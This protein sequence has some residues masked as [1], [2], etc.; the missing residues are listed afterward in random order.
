VRLHTEGRPWLQASA[1]PSATKHGDSGSTI[2][3]KGESMAGKKAP[4]DGIYTWNGRQYR[5]RAGEDMPPGAEFRALDSKDMTDS[6]RAKADSRRARQVAA[7]PVPGVLMSSSFDDGSA[8]EIAALKDQNA[9]LTKQLADLAAKVD[10]IQAPTPVV[11][12][13]GPEETTKGAGP[14]ETTTGKGAEK[15]S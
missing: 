9:A 1:G 5:A 14:T 13:K 7:T 2:L 10:A 3:T 8:K 6:E 4:D 11:A 12:G 15:T